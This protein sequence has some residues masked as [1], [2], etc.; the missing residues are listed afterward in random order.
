MLGGQVLSSGSVEGSRRLLKLLLRS[1]S[2]HSAVALTPSVGVWKR[3]LAK[4]EDVRSGDIDKRVSGLEKQVIEDR[5]IEFHEICE[6]TWDRT[7]RIFSVMGL[8]AFHYGV[9]VSM[10]LNYVVRLGNDAPTPDFL[11]SQNDD[12]ITSYYFENSPD[13]MVEAVTELKD[14]RRYK[15]LYAKHGLKELWTIDGAKKEFRV[16]R[17]TESGFSPI[18]IE[19]IYNSFS[20]PGLTVNVENIWKTYDDPWNRKEDI[21][22][23]YEGQERVPSRSAKESV[24]WGDLPFSPKIDN[25]P[26]PI[27]FDEFIAWSPESKFQWMDGQLCVSTPMGSR[28]T[29]AMLLQ[30]IGV[31]AAIP[32]LPVDDW[33]IAVRDRR[34]QLEIQNTL[35][36]E[37]IREARKAARVL[38]DDFGFSELT[39]Y[40]DWL[41]EPSINRWT[42]VWIATPDDE[43]ESKKNHEVYLALLKECDQIVRL[44]SLRNMTKAEKAEFSEHKL[45]L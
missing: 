38:R 40:G 8:N 45:S 42:D 39:L 32:M 12:Q 27:T 31:D 5:R 17:R 30:T 11:M 13:I 24:E 21:I 33:L 9:P 26:V 41:N 19:P 6:D 14:L 10:S 3:A 37:L 43:R 25:T 28:N 34:Y 44:K 35:R 29:I 2:A 4:F 18:A 36:E 22:L 20:L 23:V 1:W 16:F 15:N 7:R